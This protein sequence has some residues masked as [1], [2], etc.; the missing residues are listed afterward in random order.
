MLPF[1]HKIISEHLYE[2]VKENLGIQLNKTSLTYGSIKPDLSPSFFK[3]KHF[4]PQSF[5]IVI[6]E[7]FNLSQKGIVSNK[8]FM[9][10]YSQQIG[11]A[12]HFIADYFCVPHN[13]R[14][15]YH[16]NFL[17]HLAYEG[18]L[19]SLFKGFNEGVK[20]EPS[21]F[22]IENYSIEKIQNVVDRL[23]LSY[24]LRGEGL[25]N[26]MK[27]SIYAA[28]AVAMFIVYNGIKTASS[29]RAA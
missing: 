9:R 13:D 14:K 10:L 24:Q 12:T 7:I 5:P 15:T 25:Q 21:Q 29:K 3:V 20:V 2:N 18:E 26:D 22:N 11:E 23:H 27:S 19:H 4:K 6:K 16:K 1:T 17:N 8:E 28:S